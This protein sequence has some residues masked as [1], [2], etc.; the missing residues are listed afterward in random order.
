MG[1]DQG[2]MRGA[3]VLS[4][5]VHPAHFIR[6]RRLNRMVPFL[7]LP[8][9]V[10]ANA[11]TVSFA[12]ALQQGLRDLAAWVERGR[13]PSSTNY[14]VIDSQVQVPAKAQDRMGPQAIATLQAN[15]EA[16]ATTQAGGMVDF[17]A[18]VTVPP[19]AGKIVEIEWDFEGLGTYPLSQVIDPAL[20]ALSHSAR[21]VY[22]RA[23]TYYPV[24]RVTS[25][26]EGDHQTPFARIQN[27]AHA[28]V[29]VT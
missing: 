11:H 27:L 4:S 9:S 8:Q 24:V 20:E 1:A 3:S 29:D 12:G 7:P 22:D 21:H 28:R 15:G 10:Q 14:A 16:A 18:V 26:R 2:Q 6:Y 25:Q 13:K 5:T 23:G 19:G 17:K